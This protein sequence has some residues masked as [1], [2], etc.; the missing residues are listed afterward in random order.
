M[1]AQ[2]MSVGTELLLG[3]IIDTNAAYLAQYLAGLGINSTGRPPLATTWAASRGLRRGW[4]RADLIVMT[5]GLGPTDDDLTR[6]GI[7]AL[8]G[9]EMVVQPRSGRASPLLVRRARPPCPSATSNRP[10]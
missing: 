2:I 9:E 7:A 6:E 4:E 1:K 10:R 5:G 8:L 3:Q